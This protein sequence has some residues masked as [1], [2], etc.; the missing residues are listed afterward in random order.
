MS[1][2]GG[3]IGG[4]GRALTGKEDS[5]ARAGEAIAL[6]GVAHVIDVLESKV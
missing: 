5:T 1:D 3:N 4:E 2:K 6:L